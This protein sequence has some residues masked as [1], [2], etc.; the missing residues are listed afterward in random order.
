VSLPEIPELINE[1][2]I[3]KYEVTR[4]GN[5]TYAAPS[6]YPDDCVI[7]LA[8]AVQ[9]VTHRPRPGIYSLDD[10]FDMWRFEQE[11]AVRGYPSHPAKTVEET[12]RDI[13]RVWIPTLS[14]EGRRKK[15]R[16]ILLDHEEIVQAPREEQANA[17][18]TLM[19]DNEHLF[20]AGGLDAGKLRADIEAVVTEMFD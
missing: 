7:S 10:D 13:S 4:A 15:V 11:L 2:S 8:L 5:V 3:F 16:N 18:F 12:K 6:G 1:L 14:E 20:I 17:L 9:G 19:V